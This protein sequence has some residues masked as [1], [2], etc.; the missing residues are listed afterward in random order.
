MRK[1][2]FVTLLLLSLSVLL[3]DSTVK[4]ETINNGQFD[5]KVTELEK[6]VDDLKSEIQS[7]E[8]DRQKN[9][10]SSLYNF[11]M[12]FIAIISFFVAVGGVI[13]GLL[14]NKLKA[15]QKKI[16]MVLDS[17]DFDDKV[18][19]IEQRL[20]EI[21]M[22]E[23]YS[24]ISSA[25]RQFKTLCKEIEKIIFE[26]DYL[27]ED[28]SLAFLDEILHRYEWD[29]LKS[30]YQKEKDNFLYLKGEEIRPSDDYEDDFTNVEEELED[31]IGEI[32]GLLETFEKIE[33]EIENNILKE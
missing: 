17:K 6:K 2:I 19:A 9:I 13:L 10:T 12:L 1:Y 31:Y 18:N 30:S 29:G 22:K 25:K 33:K 21:R 16:D 5:A 15:H 28:N 32:E 20:V 7:S 26:V 24:I 27:K 11:T 23:R 4:A 14:I 8:L 3:I